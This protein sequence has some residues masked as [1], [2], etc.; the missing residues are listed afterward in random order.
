MNQNILITWTF[1]IVLAA[2][3]NG[4]LGDLQQWVWKN[5]ANLLRQSRASTWGSRRIWPSSG[6]TP[7]A[8]TVDGEAVSRMKINNNRPM[9]SSAWSL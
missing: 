2:S 4:H 7:T 3:I 8:P 9:A 1:G 6:R 5:Q